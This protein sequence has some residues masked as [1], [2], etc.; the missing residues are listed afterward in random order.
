MPKIRELPIIQIDMCTNNI[1]NRFGTVEECAEKLGLTYDRVYQMCENKRGLKRP[2]LP[3]Y[4]RYEKDGTEPHR[5]FAVYDLDFELIDTYYNLDT[6]AKATGLTYQSCFKQVK[7]NRG[8]ELR[9]RAI[10][11]TSGLYITEMEVK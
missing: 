11:P 3:Y 9:N 6:V 8:I 7:N 1:L 4:L 5:V 2:Q 10:E